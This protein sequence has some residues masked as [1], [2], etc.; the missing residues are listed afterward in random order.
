MIE[1]PFYYPV[2]I[3]S[4]NGWSRATR[5][6]DLNGDKLY[7]FREKLG[8]LAEQL[9]LLPSALGLVRTASKRWFGTWTGLLLVQGLLPVAVVYQSRR[10]VNS[11][12]L[13]TKTGANSESVWLAL[14]PGILLAATLL[15][16][17]V[18]RSAGGYVRA[19]QSELARDHVRSLI[20]EKSAGVD[21]E[22]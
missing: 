11:L 7:T 1:S 16:T 8:R 18:R 6:D 2:R 10:V 19:V 13:L 20:Q 9:P 3:V 15:A 21:L 5:N 22:F 4:S 17:E 12:V 14:W